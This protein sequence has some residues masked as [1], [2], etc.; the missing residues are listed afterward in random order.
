MRYQGNTRK[1]PAKSDPTKQI[2]AGPYPLFNTTINLVA[3]YELAVQDRKGDSFVL[4]P[5]Y[6]GNPASGTPACRTTTSAGTT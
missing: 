1:V 3:E 2:D 6:C 5:D 4:T